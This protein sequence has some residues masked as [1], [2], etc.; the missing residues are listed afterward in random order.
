MEARFPA[1]AG[2]VGLGPRPVAGI[3]AANLDVGCDVAELI[4]AIHEANDTAGSATLDLAPGCTYTLTTVD[5]ESDG[6]NGLPSITAS[7]AVNGNGAILE[8][9]RADGTPAFR[10]LRIAETAE[11]TIHQ[12][13]VRYGR[14][15]SGAG[16]LNHGTLEPIDSSVSTETHALLAGSPA[17]DAGG[18]G[19]CPVDD[20]R[21]MSRPRDGDGDDVARCDIGAYERQ[22]PAVMVLV[23]F[24]ARPALEGIPLAWETSS[25]VDNAGFYLWRSEVAADGPYLE[26]TPTPIKPRG[27]PGSGASYAY[28]DP[29][30]VVGKTYWYELQAVSHQGESAMH[31][32]VSATP[33]QIRILYLPCISVA[34]TR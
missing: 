21:G 25:E 24:A 19:A 6:P 11:V 4:A 32:P 5:H 27:V 15:G 29:D 18:D 13:T 23:S 16:I 17:T 28:T 20:Q 26:L 3:Q 22:R 7:V 12:L 2:R 31:G 30:V 33:S 1:P 8:R 10:I 9:S 34:G 14:S